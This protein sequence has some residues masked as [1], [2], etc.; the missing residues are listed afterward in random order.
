MDGSGAADEPL[1]SP[2]GP[3]L[4]YTAEADQDIEEWQRTG[5]FPFPEL[6]LHPEPRWR[7]LSATD[8]H[9]IYHVASVSSDMQ[10]KGYSHCNI[11]TAKMPTCVA[12]C[13]SSF[14]RGD[15]FGKIVADML[16]QIPQHCFL[17]RFC[18]ELDTRL[19]SQ[20]SGVEDWVRGDGR[21]GLLSP[22]GCYEGPP[23]GN[24]DFLP[25]KFRCRSGIFNPAVLA[26]Y[27]MVSTAEYHQAQNHGS[28]DII[29]GAAGCH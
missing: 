12:L 20:P 22:R 25:R 19:L 3:D 17:V 4:Q 14:L 23:S 9:L 13:P 10:V 8:L 15:L 26:G 11:W 2:R 28:W 27:R 16:R 29:L 18:D 24:R 6:M 21:A 7:H 1:R 5:V